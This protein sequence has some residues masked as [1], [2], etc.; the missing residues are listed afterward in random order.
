MSNYSSSPTL[1]NCILW[2]NYASRSGNEV[3]TS[4]YGSTPIFTYCV[5][6][7]S[8]KEGVWDEALGT[9][10][11][12]NIDSD[13][14]FVRNPRTN[15]RD[16][17]GDLHLTTQSPCI[18][19]GNNSAV[20]SWETDIDGELRIIDGVVDIGADECLDS[21]DDGM[22][23]Y[24]EARCNVDNP[25]EDSDG[26]GLNNRDECILG[27]NPAHKDS[28]RDGVVDGR[29]DNDKDGL[30]NGDEI[31]HGTNPINSDTDGDGYTDGEELFHESDPTSWNSTPGYLTTIYVYVEA[32][33]DNN[34]R[35]W[36]NAF[37]EL[38]RALIVAISGDEVWVAAGTY[39]PTSWP[40]GG[41]EDREKHFSL[42]N[43]V[44]V[45]GGFKGTETSLNDRN[46][47]INET[48]FDGDNY[49]YHV[50]YHPEGTNLDPS[51][52]LD[53][54]IITGGNAD[55]AYHSP[56]Y[57]GGGMYNDSSSPTLN[58]CIFSRNFAEDNGGGMY[59]DSSSPVLTNCTFN[60]NRAYDCG[61]GIYNL[62]SS[63]EFTHCTFSENFGVGVCNHDSSPE[64]THCIFNSNGGSGMY[65]YESSPNLTNCIFSGN[66]YSGMRN[67]E[68]SPTLTNCV[69]S[70]NSAYNGGGMSNYSSSPTL[71]NCILWNNDATDSGNEV[72]N[73]DSTP[74]FSHCDI[75]GAFNGG[76]WDEELGIDEGYNIDTDPSFVRN[77]RTNWRNDPGDLHL[78][79]NSPC[80]DRGDNNAVY[81]WG[82]DIDGESRIIGGLVDMGADEYLDAD[83]DGTPDYLEA[84]CDV[85]NPDEDSDGDG[86][87]NRDECLL[88]T[89]PTQEDSDGDGISDGQEDYDKDGLSNRDEMTYG[90]QPYTS[91]TDGDGYYDGGEIFHDSDPTSLDSTPE[92]SITIFVDV[93]A[94]GDNNGR[95][96][97]NAFVELNTALLVAI[98]GD[99]VWVAAGTY[100]PTSWP[101]GGFDDREKHFSLKNGVAV[102]GG[103][104]GTEISFDERDFETN[105]TILS[106]D[107][108]IEGDDSDNCYHIF[109]HPYG[110]DLDTTAV[111][112]GFTIIGGNSSYGGGMYND[113]SSPNIVNCTISGNLAAEGGGG[114]YNYYSSPILTNC[115]F[116]NNSAH[117]ELHWN[118]H[119]SEDIIYLGDGGGMYNYHS[120][121]TLINCIFRA[122]S[123]YNDGGGM[124]NVSSSPTLTN[125]TFRNN[126]AYHFESDGDGHGMYNSSSFPTLTNCVINGNHG[127]GIYNSSSSPTLTNCTISGNK[128]DGIYNYHSSPSVTNC[129]ISGNEN[130]GIYN[131]SSS[132]TLTNCILWG[133][134]ASRSGNEITN[135]DSVP[136]FSY[137]VI[138]GC[139]DEGV[140]D[141]ELGTDG[142]NNIDSDPLFVRNPGTNGGEDPGDLHLTANSPCI[143]MGFG[144]SNPFTPK[145][146][147]IDGEPRV[148][149]GVV[150]IGADEYWDVDD[151]GMPDNWEAKYDV[152]D[153]ND[154]PDG[155][156]LNN[157][158]ESVSGIDPTLE[159]S[160]G[161]GIVDSLE[162][163]DRDGLSNRD[164][165]THGTQPNNRDTD[166]DGYNDSAELFHESDP[167]S[168]NSIP[169][170]S[171]TIY[172]DVDAVGDSTGRDWENAFVELNRALL[173]SIPGDEIWVAAGTYRPTSWPNGGF[174]DREKHF[175][176]KNGVTVYGGFAGTE[177]SLNQRH[178]GT[179]QTVLS[180]DI[181]IEGDNSDNCYN[182][183]FH[184][185]K[186][187]LDT[188]AILDGFIVTGGNAN[189]SSHQYG[190]GM[191]NDSSSPSLANC[192]FSRN[193]AVYARDYYV[194]L[195]D[196]SGWE[197]RH[198]GRGGGIYNRD[199]F[200]ELTNCTFSDNTADDDGGGMYNTSSS[201]TLTNC[202]FSGNSADD[203]GGMYNV[204]S[205][206]SLINCFFN[207][208][209]V[210]LGG[211]GI[212]NNSSS[213]ELINCTFSSNSAYT[214]D[215]GWFSINGDG[216]GGGIFNISSS[217]TLTH[218]TFSNNWAY[219]SGGG[220]YNWSS[221]PNLTNC[222]LWNNDA[223]TSG[224]EVYNGSGS[225]TPTFFNCDIKDSFADGSWD[226]ELGTDGGNNIDSDPLFVRNPGTDGEDDPG[227][228]HLTPYS[229]CIDTGDPSIT[230]GQDMDGEVRVFDGDWDGTAI[231]DI[232]ADEYVDIDPDY[233]GIGS[234]YDNCPYIYNPMQEDSDGDGCGDACDGRP[235][236]PN[237]LTITGSITSNETPLCAMVL[238]NGKHMFTCGNTLGFY[239]L[240]VPLNEYGEITLY[241]FCSGLAPFKTVLTPEE[242]LVYDIEM[243]PAP[244]GSLE[245]ETTVQIEP[246]SRNT[247]W[248]R[249][250]G[251]VTFYGEDLC[252]MVLANGQRM[253]S[254]GDNP[255]TFDLEVP[256]DKDGEITLYVFCSGFAPYKEILVP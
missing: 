127:D 9:D 102:Y 75:K 50:F 208:N 47:E 117:E 234:Y 100:R 43:G 63:P 242:A 56:H 29:E 214:T 27:T 231:V 183:F 247:N 25:D 220:M 128:G 176:L 22:P 116:R 16:D 74:I 77:P 82:A 10:G 135:Y 4:N 52:V 67:S 80:I 105:N 252:A 171:T 179:N 137:C 120:S 232:G 198:Y 190:G 194:G 229:P 188:T 95:D 255:G 130:H 226:E 81:S 114:M 32:T 15:G 104:T 107:I 180:G 211:G 110:T 118:T 159:D 106:G 222:I 34:G 141:E 6:R 138:P 175:S 112:D 35:D 212:F 55:Y 145:G 30:T 224:N 88:G 17:P 158:E 46:L 136:I 5:I 21:N 58:N 199:S 197:T 125:C 221:S 33:G 155:D 101:N 148:I 186:I 37:V 192:M 124:F 79:A 193:T 26:D 168:L 154:D 140:W 204:S 65:N 236:N 200:P 201:P 91:D 57:D 178:V 69:F 254:C 134:Y 160:D 68:S 36:E 89:D 184:P 131:S 249:I 187:G 250:H 19:M 90:T 239:E 215:A 153:P 210:K 72:Y 64:F 126:S 123:S 85:D 144:Y 177:T 93:E 41:L 96:W 28:D 143:D 49:Y 149:G 70:G 53:G 195:P 115:I 97:E 237:W 196:M 119:S 227:D 165:I 98:P 244:E 238:A 38:D 169:A 146:T 14:L 162:D 203:G 109:Y 139:F 42:K 206:P 225:S 94:T 23:D 219:I 207:H 92:Y 76:V 84:K 167:T 202:T 156:G 166:G 66:Y 152:N 174:D 216:D 12:N 223:D 142:G 99:V 113:S 2:G 256:L 205:S 209:S 61:G 163:Y 83:D 213:P 170:Y 182:V 1:T 189:V 51:A 73:N 241:S 217:P 39:R 44:T 173:V 45:Y 233:D 71:T 246:S 8:F 191:Y 172:V 228:L 48:I 157:Q 11:G 62:H 3:F 20:D 132:P 150:D 133:N 13:P 87:N 78:T 181:G 151:D 122:N 245:I 31:I 147:D 230:D 251:T 111:L 240:D 253:F 235:D 121:P 18:D 103:F 60:D 24:L 59:N 40:N 164:E 7:G 86:L 108:G 54:V 218:C 243:F 185:K 161:D 129:T 248:R